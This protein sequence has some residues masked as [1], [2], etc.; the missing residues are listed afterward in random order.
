MYHAQLY[1]P[2]TLFQTPSAFLGGYIFATLAILDLDGQ[3]KGQVY[4]M[5][6]QSVSALTWRMHVVRYTAYPSL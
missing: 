5:C 6:M 4:Y 2:F 3:F 1:L